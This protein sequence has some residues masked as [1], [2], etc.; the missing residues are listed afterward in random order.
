MIIN[1]ADEGIENLDQ[2]E[3]QDEIEEQLEGQ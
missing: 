1:E 2:Q 3:L